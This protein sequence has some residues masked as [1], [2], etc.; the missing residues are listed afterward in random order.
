M[1]IVIADDSDLLR[2]RIK[3]SLK[4]IAEVEIVGEAKDGI[5]AIK[6]IHEKNPDLVLL[7]I[8]MP[9]LDG[10]GVLKRMKGNESKSKVWIFTNYPYPQYEKKCREEGADYFF[11]KNV[12]FQEVKNMIVQFTMKL[13]GAD[14]E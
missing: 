9:K 7:D 14:D 4:D 6:I 5:E 13:T 11:D 3:E 12:N 8:R 10:I 1:K 2:E